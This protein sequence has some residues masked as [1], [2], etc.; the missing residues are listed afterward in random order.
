VSLLLSYLTPFNNS[1]RGLA[2][3]LL[4]LLLSACQLAK[5]GNIKAADLPPTS[6][7]PAPELAAQHQQNLQAISDFFIHGRMAVQYDG[8]G[9][10]GQIQWRKQDQQQHIALISPL[11][12]SIAEIDLDAQQ[13]TLTQ[14]DGKQYQA[15]DIE[16]LTQQI[17]GWPLPAKQLN[18]W[19]VGRTGPG[20]ISEPRWD[21]QGRLLSFKQADWTVEYSDYLA[22]DLFATTM[23]EAQI[24]SSPVDLPVKLT[25]RHPKMY[26]RLIVDEWHLTETPMPVDA[27]I[28]ATV[29]ATVDAA[30]D[31]ASQQSIAAPAATSE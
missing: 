14:S 12:N 2:I 20:L 30:I 31:Q 15:Q 5:N 8:H 9:Y 7:Q 3:A 28:D 19:I 11:G 1:L 25:L 16:M 23:P 22:Q 21:A 10:S 4:A 13:V 29:E 6:L 17:L 27:P 26:L 24:P 18:D